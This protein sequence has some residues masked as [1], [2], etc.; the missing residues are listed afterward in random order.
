MV[1]GVA[2]YEFPPMGILIRSAFLWPGLAPLWLRGQWSG[3]ATAIAFG[4]LLNLALLITFAGFPAATSGDWWLPAAAWSFVLGFWVLTSWFGRTT[5]REP[6]ARRDGWFR[7]AQT[8]YLK[9]HW[10]ESE[11]LLGKL[12]TEQAEDVEA[13][14]LLASVLR[15]TGRRG[16]AARLLSELNHDEAAAGWQWEVQNEMSRIAANQQASETRRKAA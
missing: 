4:C 14:L 10:I 8:H 6:V 3:L 15:R 1:G 12:L 11:T 13:R 5:A 16:E 9:G 7:D 2:D